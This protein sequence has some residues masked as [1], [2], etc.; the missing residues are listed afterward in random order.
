MIIFHGGNKCKVTWRPGL[1]EYEIESDYIA[2]E[3]EPNITAGYFRWCPILKQ[4]TLIVSHDRSFTF[5]F[6]QKVWAGLW[7]EREK[8][9]EHA[10]SPKQGA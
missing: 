1:S 5:E 3:R 9:I 8:I 2:K 6:I 4:W 7:M 10:S